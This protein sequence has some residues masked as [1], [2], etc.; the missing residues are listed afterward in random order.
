MNFIRKYICLFVT[1]LCLVSCDSFLNMQPTDSANAD[2]AIAT[3]QD[4]QVAINGIMRAMTADVYYGRNI[5]LYADAKG[6]D[7]T[8]VSNS[9]V[10]CDF[11]TFDHSSIRGSYSTF[12]SQI[13]YCIMQVN[14]L[15]EN[16]T[17]LEAEGKT[18]LEPYKGQALTLRALFYFDLVRLYGLPYNYKP[19]SLG[20]PR[21]MQTLDASAQPIRATVA[22]NYADIC[23]D[24][25]E[26]ELLLTNDI[27]PKRGYVGYYANLA[28]QARVALYM[29]NYELALEKAEMIIANKMFYRLYTND[30]W[31]KSWS[32]QFGDESILELC[33]DSENDL[34]TSSLGIYHLSGVLAMGV[35]AR[36]VASEYYLKH[37]AEDSLDVRWEVMADDEKSIVGARRLGS[38][39]K[40]I[41]G[42]DMHGDGKPSIYATNIKIIRLSEIYLIAAEAALQNGDPGKAADYLNLIRK[43]APM[44]QPATADN[45]TLSMILDER[46]K[47]LYGEGHR[48]FD[49]IRCNQTI[50]YN[51]DFQNVPVT[52]RSKTIDR[53]FYGIVLPIG[54][55]ELNANAAMAQQQ[56]PG[57]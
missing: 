39:L 52:R 30:E 38:C 44:L 12:W 27:T 33:I 55:D 23:R 19:S 8:I 22:E 47:E 24:L 16:I 1:A 43:R 13:Y 4:V 9:N 25:Q 45:I 35:A 20:V 42:P 18:G 28:L 7:M 11:Y 5:M 3:V 46:S 15:L 36:Y 17:R 57:Y 37:L 6:G 10:L 34:G 56:N 26:A 29:E 32:Q 41:G 50:E 54:Q 2:E 40:Y 14:N 31:A 49:R 53:T 51:D 48:F 21:I